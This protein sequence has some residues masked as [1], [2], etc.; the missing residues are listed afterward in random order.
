MSYHVSRFGPPTEALA[1]QY[2]RLQQSFLEKLF[3]PWYTSSEVCKLRFSDRPWKAGMLEKAA[4]LLVLRRNTLWI[5][6][7]VGPSIKADRAER[8]E[9]VQMGETQAEQVSSPDQEQKIPLI[10]PTEQTRS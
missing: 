1:L 7:G 10:S 8:A 6:D 5:I 3:L 2:E 4:T 9:P